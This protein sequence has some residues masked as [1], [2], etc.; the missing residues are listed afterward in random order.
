MRP[1]VLAKTL[2]AASVNTIAQ[3]QSLGAAGN[4]SLN[5]SAASAG[6]ATLDTQ[7]RVL[8]TSAGNDSGITFTVFGTNQGGNAI[9]ETVT[10]AIAGAAATNQDFLTVTRVAN[11]GA[12]ASTVQVGTN[13][14]GSSP[15]AL[16]DPHVT[17][18]NLGL[19]VVVTGTATFTVEYSYDDITSLAPGVFA[20]VFAL[21]ALAAKTTNTDSNIT[22]PIRA[23]RLTLTSNTPPGGATLTAIQAGIR[24]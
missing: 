8:V 6:V 7:R 15:W 22:W 23:V 24:Q 10:G 16:I 14:V 3:S 13:G 4:F 18:C 20:N 11:S 1:V 2:A 17:P 5:G 21:A 19:G 12:T 9:Q